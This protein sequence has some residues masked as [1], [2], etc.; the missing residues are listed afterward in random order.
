MTFF[1]LLCFFSFFSSCYLAFDSSSC[2]AFFCFSCHFHP[3]SCL[4]RFVS[5][6]SLSSLSFILFSF[7]CFFSPIDLLC[8]S[9]VCVVIDTM[10]NIYAV[11]FLGW[12]SQQLVSPGV[13][14]FVPSCRLGKAYCEACPSRLVASGGGSFWRV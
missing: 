3:F 11:V 13:S 9:C 10:C 7:L 5:F 8:L 6:S 12:Q 2:L 4:F 14:Y 1:F